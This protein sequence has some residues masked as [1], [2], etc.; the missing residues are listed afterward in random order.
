MILELKVFTLPTCSVCPVAKTIALEVAEEFGIDYREVNMAV[1]DG[2]DEG[3]VF[4]I[5]STPSI[6]I[7]D[8]VIATG[9]LVSKEKLVEEV[10][11]RVERWRERASKEEALIP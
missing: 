10:K 6:A 2:L 7:D 4:D 9:R 8:E 5:L 3:V 1:K 11:K